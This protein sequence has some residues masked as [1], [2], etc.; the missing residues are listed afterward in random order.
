MLYKS[1]F[2]NEKDKAVERDKWLLKT[3]WFPE[4]M[5]LKSRIFESTQNMNFIM[6]IFRQQTQCYLTTD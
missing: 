4:H 1:H 2:L 6:S 5:I 3:S